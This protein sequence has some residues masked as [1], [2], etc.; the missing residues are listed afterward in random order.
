MNIKNVMRGMADGIVTCWSKKKQMIVFDLNRFLSY[1]KNT[2]SFVIGPESDIGNA[3]HS[4]T[5]WLT[6]LLTAVATVADVDAEDHVG[7]SLLIWELMFGHTAKLLFRLLA[8]G[9]VKI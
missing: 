8:Q 2:Q 6:N 5:H 1:W 4:L 9:L 3:C 7:N